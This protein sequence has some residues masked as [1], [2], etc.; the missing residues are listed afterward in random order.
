MKEILHVSL[1]TTFISF[2]SSKKLPIHAQNNLVT[3]VCQRLSWGLYFWIWIWIQDSSHSIGSKNQPIQYIDLFTT[4]TRSH[5]QHDP[6]FNIILIY[7]RLINPN[8]L[9][10]LIILV[11]ESTQLLLILVIFLCRIFYISPT[12]LPKALVHI[13]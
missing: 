8:N 9:S 5:I 4:V 1:F 6:P 3:Y 2:P 13:Y 11:E 12:N 10:N 7:C